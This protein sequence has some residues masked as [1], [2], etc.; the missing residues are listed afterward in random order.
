MARL[1][2]IDKSIM[3]RDTALKQKAA[4]RLLLAVLE[5]IYC[6]CDHAHF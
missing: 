6:K 1:W 4:A 5:R 2:Q 3:K